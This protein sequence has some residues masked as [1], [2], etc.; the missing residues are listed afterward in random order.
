MVSRD[1]SLTWKGEEK[2]FSPTF[3]FLRRVDAKLQGDGDRRSNLF[4]VAKVI[5]AGGSEIMDVPIVMSMFLA[6]AGFSASEEECW[7]VLSAVIS[8]DASPSQMED[9]A[10]FGLAVTNAILPQ[11]DFGKNPDAPSAGAPAV[12]GKRASRKSTGTAAI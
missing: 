11:V 9:Y 5:N 8:G 10:S 1:L 12:K 4:T 7:H 6:E 2:T 3:R